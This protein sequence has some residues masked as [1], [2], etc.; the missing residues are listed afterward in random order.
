MPL[1]ERRLL[2]ILDRAADQGAKGAEVLF[3]RIEA[4]SGRSAAGRL[5]EDHHRT[6][7][8]V[9]VRVWLEGG[10]AGESTC[11]ADDVTDGW[12]SALA[13]A[14]TRAGK[15]AP[16][17][18]AGPVGRLTGLDDGLGLMDRRYASTP[19]KERLAVIADAERGARKVDRRVKTSDFVYEDRFVERRFASSKGNRGHERG[20]VYQAGGT[21]ELGDVVLRQQLD[22]RT[23]AG[24]A[25]LPFGTVLAQRAVALQGRTVE[26]PEGPLRVALAARLVGAIFE[27]L[28]PAFRASV[29]EAGG[30]VLL[31][32][33]LSDKVHLLDDGSMP[34]ALRTTAF[35][36]RGVAPVP[37]TLI[38]DG[39][40]DGRYLAPSMARRLDTR[41]TGHVLCGEDRPRNLLVRGGSRSINAILSDGQGAVFNAEELHELVACDPATGQLELIVHGR[42]M[43][44]TDELGIARHVR[45]RG[46]LVTVLSSV[47]DVSSDTDR[48]GHVDAPGYLLDGFVVA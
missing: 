24:I 48:F 5:V 43:N 18:T 22:D 10:A 40:V 23:F 28:A 46:D 4:L 9:D 45:L 12:E 20:T 13:E 41:P 3:T 35:D 26:L 38:R 6:S 44:G 14:L 27:A 33:E 29:L 31:G 39:Q 2:Q 37:L 25:S 7:E 36:D 47:V 19:I 21:V 32:Q 16:D 30:N 11:L 8:S 34:G 1:D 17:P 42:S 15:A